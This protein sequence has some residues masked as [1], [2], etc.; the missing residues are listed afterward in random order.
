MWI[1]YRYFI[2]CQ[3]KVV[4]GV[5]SRMGR[6][7]GRG[8]FGQALGLAS[9]IKILCFIWKESNDVQSTRISF[10]SE[11][12]HYSVQLSVQTLPVEVSGQEKLTDVLCCLKINFVLILIHR[13]T[14][15]LLRTLQN[16]LT[17]MIRLLTTKIKYNYW[18]LY[19][20]FM[21]AYVFH[22]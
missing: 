18:T 1:V 14:Y 2:Y 12:M 15:T 16:A 21:S 11:F 10:L 9:L 19:A 20:R 6:A 7:G 22:H 8:V 4:A 5:A 13:P 3:A 17:Y